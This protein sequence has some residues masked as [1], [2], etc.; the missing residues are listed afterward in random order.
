MK[1]TYLLPIFTVILIVVFFAG[2][3]A[4]RFCPPPQRL[5]EEKSGWR[6]HWF[7][8]VLT[9]CYSLAA[10]L[11]LGDTRAPQSFRQL[12]NQ[13]AVIELTEPSPIGRIML[14]TGIVQG[15]YSIEFSPDGETWL[16]AASYEQ[17]HAAL[18]KWEEPAM[19]EAPTGVMRAVRITGYDGAEL[20]EV[21]L[22]SPQGELLGT[23][24]GVR[25][26]CDEQALVPD[27]PYYLNSSYF[28]EIY[29]ARTAWEHLRGIY[30]YEISHP[31]LG[32]EILSLGILL[33]GM[34]PFGWRF[35]GTLF[36][37]AMLPVIYWFARKLFG[38][39]TVPACCAVLLA[40]DFMHFAQTRIATIDTYGVFFILLMY[41]FMYDF[42]RTKS[43]KALA[44]SGVFFG[45]GA[46]SK[47]TCLYAGAGLGVLW[48]AHWVRQLRAVSPEGR[49]RGEV[50]DYEH[51]GEAFLKNVGFCLIFFVAIPALIYYLSYIPYG[52]A[53]GCLPF[54]GAYTKLVWD[55]QVFMFTYHKGVD[56]T[57]PYSSRWY[58][59]ILDIRPILFYYKGL[60]DGWRSSFGSWLNPVLCWSGL[61]GLFVLLYMALVRR[62]RKAAF[63]LWA[64]FAQL[65]PWLLITRTTFEYHY[66]PSSVFLVLALG[67]VFSLM[68]DCEKN[69]K[70]RVFGLCALSAA[71]FVLFYPAL[72]GLPVNGYEATKYMKWLPTW[73]F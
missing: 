52:A 61:L 25:E 37:A 48:L 10:F 11:N 7:I 12:D 36:G 19:S 34:T 46:A 66:F 27:T 2:L 62:E 57:H 4:L 24:C 65:L 44:L 70:W 58:Q 45:L 42:L 49:E 55:N 23:S 39:R 6:R 14:Y 51:P 59:W 71:V 9:L 67:Y 5:A 18:L 38:G 63:L 13:Y 64:Y 53:R 21:A 28:D 3:P 69:W 68:R 41:G 73:P 60:D 22:F 32:K 56:A 15:S 47:W 26:F 54:S 72:S 35:M 17:G 20:G 16:P 40:T 33:F 8:L 1:A 29:H 50:P 43:R 30:P 31:P